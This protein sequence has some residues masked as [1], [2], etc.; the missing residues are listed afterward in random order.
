MSRSLFAWHRR[1]VVACGV[2]RQ[3]SAQKGGTLIL[4][5]LALL[6][7]QPGSDPY[8]LSELIVSVIPLTATT[9]RELDTPG[10]VSAA[11]ERIA[12]PNSNRAGASITTKGRPRSLFV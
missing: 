2:L 12:A 5:P 7:L 9:S 4:P 11:R 10:R 3:V 1:I 6:E 8:E